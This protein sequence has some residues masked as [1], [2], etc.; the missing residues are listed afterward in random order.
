MRTGSLTLIDA[1]FG[2][3]NGFIDAHQP[4]DF[5]IELE[6]SVLPEMSFKFER[7]LGVIVAHDEYD[8]SA[9]VQ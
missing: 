6:T 2:W 9:V 5:S 4:V 1:R 8:I 7:K 3:R